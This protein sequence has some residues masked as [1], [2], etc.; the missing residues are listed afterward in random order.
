M[1]RN[2]TSSADRDPDLLHLQLVSV[3]AL[4]T[5]QMLGATP[6]LLDTTTVT[7]ANL[8]EE[9]G[10]MRLADRCHKVGMRFVTFGT[11]LTYRA[12]YTHPGPTVGLAPS[13]P[14]R[15]QYRKEPT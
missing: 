6:H 11:H 15:T 13:Y 7:I 2:F 12:R 5:L 14:A 9:P 4:N 1:K 3:S 8:P 10:T